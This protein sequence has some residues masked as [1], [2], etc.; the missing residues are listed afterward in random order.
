MIVYVVATLMLPKRSADSNRLTHTSPLRRILNEFL[1][2]GGAL[3]MMANVSFLIFIFARLVLHQGNSNAILEA[4]LCM[5]LSA[6]PE[7]LQRL[8][9]ERVASLQDFVINSLEVLYTLDLSDFYQQERFNSLRRRKF[10]LN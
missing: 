1:C 2:C 8:I 10:Y 7:F 6:T 4:I 9:L 5:G 3:E